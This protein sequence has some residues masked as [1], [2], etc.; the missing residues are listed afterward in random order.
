[1][2]GERRLDVSKITISNLKGRALSNELARALHEEAKPKTAP[3]SFKK[4]SKRK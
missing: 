4:V 1:M 2:S 3:K